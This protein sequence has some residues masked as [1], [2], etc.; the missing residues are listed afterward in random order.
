MGIGTA[1]GG[2]RNASTTNLIEETVR[3]DLF[4]DYDFS[5]K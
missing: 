3:E 4:G 1:V 2:F 5:K